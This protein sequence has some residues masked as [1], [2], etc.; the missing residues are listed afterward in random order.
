MRRMEHYR[1][2]QIPEKEQRAKISVVVT[3]Y[4]IADY[5]ERGVRSVCAQTYRNLEVIVVDDGSTDRTPAICDALAKQDPRIR[6]IH[7]E[8]GGPAQARNVGMKTAT[9]EVIGFVDG[10]DWID[11][12]LYEKLYS[13]MLVQEADLAICFEGLEALESYVREEKQYAIQNAAWNK[14]YRREL[15]QEI[16]FPEGKWYEDIMFATAALA[17][18]GRSIYLDTALY[19]YIIDREGSIMNTQINPRTFTDQIPAYYEKTEFLK[20]IGREDL[21]D[22]HDYFFYKRLLLFYNRLDLAAD[23]SYRERIVAIVKRDAD[24][25]QRAFRCDLAAPKERRRAALFLKSRARYQRSVRWEEQVVIPLK[26]A[27]KKLLGR[28]R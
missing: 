28:S 15:L 23:A 18:A 5:I 10:D 9:G 7:K 4:N 11:P 2:A 3:A 8:N 21:A 13:A 26:I 16:T 1:P 22:I 20:K 27:G 24:R 25:M 6:V 14:L 19:N 17:R 12:D